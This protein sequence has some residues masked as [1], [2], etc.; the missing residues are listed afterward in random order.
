MK[1]LDG[2]AKSIGL[3]AAGITAFVFTASIICFAV[4]LDAPY[5]YWALTGMPV[6]FG[7]VYC[8]GYNIKMRITV[9]WRRDGIHRSIDELYSTTY[10]SRKEKTLTSLFL[11]ISLAIPLSIFY[12]LFSWIFYIVKA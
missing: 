5:I 6:L 8:F 2:E 1:Q 7:L 9:I 12:F 3:I 10:V 11:A 4:F